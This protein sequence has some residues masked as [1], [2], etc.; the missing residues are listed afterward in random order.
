M[1]QESVNKSGIRFAFPVH[2]VCDSEKPVRTAHKAQKETA[3]PSTS[4]NRALTAALNASLYLLLP[5]QQQQ[6]G[7]EL[8]TVRLE[9]IAE[10][11]SE[12]LPAVSLTYASS[13]LQVSATAA[14]RGSTACWAASPDAISTS[15]CDVEPSSRAATSTPKCSRVVSSP[16]PASS[17]PGAAITCATLL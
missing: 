2:K 1:S 10:L 16:C 3:S 6:N 14:A 11:M 9:S 5:T 17:R 4:L 12:C 8:S 7:R 15:G 13:C